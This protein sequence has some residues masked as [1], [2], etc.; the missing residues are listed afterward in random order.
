[1]KIYFAGAIRG[2]RTKLEDYSELIS[3]LSSKQHTVLT[4]HVG[5]KMISNSGENQLDELIYSRDIQLLSDSDCI[6]AEVST[7]SHGVGIEIAKAMELKKPILCLY[8]TTS[9]YP[10]S[11]MI[12]GAGL[13]CITYNTHVEETFNYILLF[14]NKIK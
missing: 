6:I 7:P 10:L 2:G 14:L 12:L 1:M 11:A 9:E 5:C 8:H 4:E 13:D 3:F